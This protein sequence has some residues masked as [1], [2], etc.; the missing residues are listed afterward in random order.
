MSALQPVVAEV[1][2][3][4]AVKEFGYHMG[5][6]MCPRLKRRQIKPMFVY[7]WQGT[8]SV[9]QCSSCML[10]SACVAATEESLYRAGKSMPKRSAQ[11]EAP[12][13]ESQLV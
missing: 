1:F 8:L 9:L 4:V 13:P 10:S 6:G 11:Q 5:K 7:L 12:T 3:A 2:S